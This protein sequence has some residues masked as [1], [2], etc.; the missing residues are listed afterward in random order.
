MALNRLRQREAKGESS[1]HLD[2]KMSDGST[3]AWDVPITDLGESKSILDEAVVQIFK[4]ARGLEIPRFK[5]EKNR[6]PANFR[7]V[8]IARVVKGNKVFDG[9]VDV[10]L[11]T[12]WLVR[13]VS[14]KGPVLAHANFDQSS[15][16]YLPQFTHLTFPNVNMHRA[17]WCLQQASNAASDSVHDFGVT[18]GEL[19]E[20]VSML[21]SPL[22]AINKICKK[23]FLLGS[24]YH[25][26]RNGAKSGFYAI[27]PHKSVKHFAKKTGLKEIAQSGSYII[28][29]S[30]NFWLSWRFG[31]Q[32]FVK[33]V[34]DIM[35]LDFSDYESSQ[36][37]I[38]RKRSTDPWKVI[39][40]SSGGS[41]GG[42]IAYSL[43]DR[44]RT[45]TMSQASY[46]F[47][48]KHGFGLDDFMNSYGVGLRHI[49]QVLWELVPCSF[50]LDRF[51]DVG[52]FI[53]SLTPDPN[54]KTLGT[55]ISEKTE[56]ILDRTLK[57]VYCTKAS[58][59]SYV[60]REA[61]KFRIWCDRYSRDVGANVP[62][63]PLLNPK[64]LKLKQNID[65]VTLLWQRLP[66]PR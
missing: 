30:S 36:L 4:N 31:V 63:F 1:I 57:E 55:C 22:S 60:V 38:A 6:N 41:L 21:V 65:H 54:V 9:R 20:T 2:R 15:C 43:N 49:P 42:F 17:L 24:K 26:V 56:F 13:E 28:N 33:E 39:T 25:F 45:R 47:S 59:T 44:C 51:V 32:P 50:V 40:G 23:A 62:I 16:P 53:K 19:A 34:G 27:T 12:N 5:V 3:S 46:A 11:K 18:L 10:S 37:K 52:A 7:P 61:K 48:V 29:N 66:K 58:S 64:L 35:S 8:R 14:V